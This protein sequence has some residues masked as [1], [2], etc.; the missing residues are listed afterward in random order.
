M[1]ILPESLPQRRMLEARAK[2]AAESAASSGTG[3][4]WTNL[5]HLFEPLSILFP[6]GTGTRLRLNLVLLA[7][8]D[9]TFF[10]VGMG[11][12]TV[13]IMYAERQFHWR[14]LEV[15]TFPSSSPRAN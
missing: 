1:F 9:C 11:A 3:K 2:H 12:M 5:S 13:I 4:H 8:I 15:S 6:T 7:A 14:N 10:G